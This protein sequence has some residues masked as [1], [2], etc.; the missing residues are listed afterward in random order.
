MPRTKSFDE[1]YE[2]YEEWF[3]KHRYVYHSELKAIRHF[4]PLHGV[5]MEI[6]VGSGRFASP[7]GIKVGIEPSSAMRKIARE[8]GI[9]VYDGVAENLP[10]ESKR[11][12]YALMVTTI[13]FVDDI[14]ASF[15]EAGRILKDEGLFIIGFV[16]KESPLGGRYQMHKNENVFYR[17]ATFYSTEEV[18]SLLGDCGFKKPRVI[19]TIFGELSGI[20]TI[21]DFKEGYGEGGFVVVQAKWTSA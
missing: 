18:L 15:Q 21:Q 11:F 9:E 5:G 8:R 17:E 10:F 14:V 20:Q 7:F 4:L 12:D 6:G 1:Y 2:Q 13:C 3:R 16:D 19:Q